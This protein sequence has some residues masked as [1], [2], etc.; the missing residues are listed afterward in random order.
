MPR[1]ISSYGCNVFPQGSGANEAFR[2]GT[3]APNTDMDFWLLYIEYP[4]AGSTPYWS[5]II[6]GRTYQSI[7]SSVSN[8]TNGYTANTDTT[9]SNTG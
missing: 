9:P 1:M 2:F 4:K 8:P 3:T 5:P 7:P 6:D